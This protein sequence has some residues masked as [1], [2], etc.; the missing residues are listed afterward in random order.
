M[1]FQVTELK[2]QLQRTNQLLQ[3]K[4][5]EFMNVVQ[6]ENNA[7]QELK[8]RLKVLEEEKKLLEV[9]KSVNWKKIKINRISVAR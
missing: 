4:Q 9:K 1:A 7:I 8:D 3:D 5:K 2:E 6:T